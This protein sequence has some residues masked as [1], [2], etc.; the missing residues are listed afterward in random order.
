MSGLRIISTVAV[1][2]I[3]SLTGH[4]AARADAHSEAGASSA[5]ESQRMTL[6]KDKIF[7]QAYLDFSLSSDAVAKPISVAP[8]VWYGLMDDLSLG[9]VHSSSG[10]IGFFGGAGSGLCFTGSDNGCPSFYSNAALL[11]RYHLFDG[12]A[13]PVVLAADGGL[14]F[15]DFDPFTLSLKLGAVGKV[16]A[17]PVD[18]LFGANLLL[19]ITERD[20]VVIGDTEVGGNK[21]VISLPVSALYPVL[22][23]LAVGVQTG[24]VLPLQNLADTFFIPFAVAGR[25]VVTPQIAVEGA[26]S[27]PSLLGSDAAAGFDGRVLSVG[28]GYI[29]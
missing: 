2:L 23:E 10:S 24:L 17:G 21:E 14:V 20:G 27:F 18:V 19:G 6:P 12:V 25:Y 8:D 26:F 29:L 28:V 3:V 9:L 5:K 13:Q 1:A 22:P 16:G 15:R 11:A 7:I 4:Q